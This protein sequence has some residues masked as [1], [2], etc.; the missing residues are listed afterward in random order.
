MFYR[1]KKRS[2]SEADDVFPVSQ[3]CCQV[4]FTHTDTH[5]LR[6]VQT[7][8]R[9]ISACP[10]VPTAPQRGPV[11]PTWTCTCATDTHLTGA[12]FKPR[13]FPPQVLRVKR[14]LTR[15]WS[16]QIRTHTQKRDEETFVIFKCVFTELKTSH[17]RSW[18]LR[19]LKCSSY[20]PQTC[21][22]DLILGTKGEEELHAHT[23]FA[24][25]TLTWCLC[26]C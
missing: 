10:F 25:H 4:G 26:F 18:I 21:T 12:L 19:I 11:S 5:I 13:L 14:P 22:P 9:L 16:F 24:L 17:R 7:S 15:K 6:R 23:R 8:R 2:A 3:T 1:C 20:R